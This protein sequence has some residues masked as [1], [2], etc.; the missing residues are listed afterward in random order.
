MGFSLGFYIK[1][2]KS[3]RVFSFSSHA[4]Y[5]RCTKSFSSTCPIQKKNPDSN[6]EHV[7]EDETK[8]KIYSD[9]YAPLHCYYRPQRVLSQR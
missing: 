1:G 4:Q 2:A 5:L 7:F 3:Q 6:F 8:M 9:I